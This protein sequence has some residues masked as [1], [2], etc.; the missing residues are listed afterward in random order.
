[1]AGWFRHTFAH[2]HD[3]HDKVDDVMESSERGFWAT[4][5]ALVSLA[6]TTGIQIVIVWFSG[7]TALS[8]RFM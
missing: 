3:V 1:V 6:I 4:K 2:S 5:W 7:S 8:G